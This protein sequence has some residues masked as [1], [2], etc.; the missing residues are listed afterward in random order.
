LTSSAAAERKDHL[1]TRI[2]SLTTTEHS[3]MLLQNPSFI[4]HTA[5]GCMNEQLASH[6]ETKDPGMLDGKRTDRMGKME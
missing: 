3:K 2:E 6:N 4:A 1:V 5:A